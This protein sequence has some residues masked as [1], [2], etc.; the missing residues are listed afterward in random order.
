MTNKA[1]TLEDLTERFK[2]LSGV[3][4]NEVSIDDIRKISSFL[5]SW[6]LVALYLGLSEGE[7][8]AID[9][10]GKSEEEKRWLML[11]R[12]KQALV[13]NATYKELINGLL[14]VR[15]ADLAVKV[16]Q[17]IVSTSSTNSQLTVGTHLE[18][19]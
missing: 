17:T 4:E 15:R 6:K 16:C 13:F 19:Q 18:G 1:I 5:E 12:W 2:I 9:K 3:L 7:V 8:E 14:S 10:D 11:Q